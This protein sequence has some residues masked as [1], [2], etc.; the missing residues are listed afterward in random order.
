MN[1]RRYLSVLL[2]ASVLI[3]NA[4]SAAQPSGLKDISLQQSEAGSA[5]VEVKPITKGAGLVSDN[6]IAYNVKLKAGND[7]ICNYVITASCGNVSDSINVSVKANSSYSGDFVLNNCPKGENLF[8]VVVTCNGVE[9]ASYAKSLTIT[10]TVPRYFLDEVTAKLGYNTPYDHNIYRETMEAN[11][12]RAMRTEFSQ[13]K[14]VESKKGQYSFSHL[15]GYMN[16]NSDKEIL[17]L[18]GYNNPIYMD[19]GTGNGPD[20]KTNIDGFAKYSG[21][22]AEHYPQLKNIEIWN[23]PN[24]FFWHNPNVRD[25]EYTAEVSYYEIK[26][27][28]PDADV[29]VGSVANGD[30]KFLNDLLSFGG[31]ENCDTV[32]YHPYTRPSTVDSAMKTVTQPCLDAIMANGGWKIPICS[33]IG[34]P[35][36]NVGIGISKEQHAHELAKT[37]IF[38]QSCGVPLTI[39]HNTFDNAWEGSTND[40]E[41]YYGIVYPDFRPKPSFYSTAEVNNETNGAVHLGKA[42]FADSNIQM[43]LYAR[44]NQIHAAIWTKGDD[45]DVKL[46][47]SGLK[48]YDEIG[49][50]VE[51]N[52][53][54]V[55]I[56]EP[57]TYV[58]GLDKSYAYR[59]IA[60]NFKETLND[61]MPNLDDCNGAKGFD[62][63]KKIL[64]SSVDDAEKISAMPSGEEALALLNKH[65]EKAGKIIEMYKNGELDIPFKRFTALLSI[66]QMMGERYVNLYMLSEDTLA[67]IDSETAVKE[68]RSAINEK[69][70][71]NTLAGADSIWKY[72]RNSNNKANEIAQ[73]GE[74]NPMKSG[75][76][77]AKRQEAVLISKLAE[78][79]AEAEAVGYN[80]ILLQLPSSQK[81]IDLGKE[82][83]IKLSLYNYREKTDLSGKIEIYAPDGTLVGE[84]GIVTL[85]AGTSDIVPTK[86]KVEETTDGEYIMKF[87]EN[88]NV[89]VQ[90][91]APIEVKEQIGV[92]FRPIIKTV[93]ELDTIT[94]RLE[95]L[96]DTE[97]E[98]DI[99]I[100]PRC[101]WSLTGGKQH[102]KIDKG[103]KKDLSFGIDKKEKEPFNFYTFD[104]VV[105][106]SEGNVVYNK[107]LPL[108]FTV[109]AKA[110]KSVAPVDFTGD[111]SDWSDAYPI[112][113]DTP[114]N[115]EDYAEWQAEDVGARMMMKWDENYYY[116][117]CDVYDQFQINHQ[118][119]AT[120]WNGDSLQLVWD[121]LNDD[122][123]HL[124]KSDD[125]EYGF[126]L[127]QFGPMAYSWQAGSGKGGEMPSEWLNVYDNRDERLTRY[128]IRI[129]SENLSPLNFTEGQIFGFN[130][131]VN[132]ADFSSREKDIEY[133]WGISVEKDPSSYEDFK[134][135]GLQEAADGEVKIP[136]PLNLDGIKKG[137]EAEETAFEDIKGHWAE[138]QIKSLAAA[139]ILSGVNEREFQ[140]QRLIT[141]AE[142]TTALV[143]AAGGEKISSDSIYSDVTPDSWYA[144]F[145]ASAK[146]AGWISDGMAF[147]NFYPDRP[148]TREEA[149]YMINCMRNNKTSEYKFMGNISDVKDIAAWAAES[150]QNLYNSKIMV[151]DE[152]GKLNPKNGMTRGEAARLIALAKE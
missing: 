40:P 108:D 67:D 114:Q 74:T 65:Y 70:G 37:S 44:D 79:V 64:E 129:P 133:T 38:Q 141:R 39:I 112:Y 54:T 90:R 58:H 115:P 145:V 96:Y 71:D 8:S 91:T 150:V 80:N 95:N 152:N 1:K 34:W 33:E 116:I 142:F 149:A 47:T 11:G 52:E 134:L 144:P 151:G 45:T 128:Y 17:G 127:T 12:A 63:A 28:N 24:I 85:K 124:Y 98:G 82:Q 4:A 48:A 22:M 148:I 137:N 5:L 2:A 26:R 73:K 147:I 121:T 135:V 86:I 103:E 107:Y 78:G 81:G 35:S 43:H 125:Y 14:S 36:N 126:A 32:S 49:N 56:S 53:S 118:V 15:D 21:K 50:P 27:K 119:G 10:S 51:T 60:D 83:E 143:L 55:H 18:L 113:C 46:D 105:T 77:N 42:F 102:F 92:S 94:V 106:N 130:F 23:E 139:G 117:L 41:G 6:N 9:V 62:E 131:L 66:M 136:I 111:I 140:P 25:Y 120:I 93:E 138:E 97:V 29:M 20:S 88:G 84:S 101:N 69:K 110:K 68:A 75:Y 87:I 132:D 109:V 59:F 57:I 89:I 146:K 123:E 16:A 76:I 100:E 61:Y 99:T 19:S 13:W 3:G 122:S 72:A 31:W 104:I 30:A 7:G